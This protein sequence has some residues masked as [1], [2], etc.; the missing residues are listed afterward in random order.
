MTRWLTLVFALTAAAAHAAQ[1]DGR[2]APGADGADAASPGAQVAAGWWDRL[3]PEQRERLR[4][5]WQQYREFGPESREAL[6]RRF[7]SLE[8]ERELLYRRMSEEERRRFE[9]MDDA[10]RRRFLDERLR[11]RFHDRADRWR[12]REPGLTEGLGDLTPEESSRRV[13]RFVREAHLDRARRELD[14]A[15]AEGWVGP[16][17]AEWLAQSSPDELFTAVGQ[18]QRWRFLDRAQRDGFWTKHGIGAEDRSRML[19]LPI[20][21]FFE[22]VRRLE[23][24]EPLLGPPCDWRRDGG[25]HGFDREELH[26]REGGRRGP[27]ER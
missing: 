1:Q 24:G 27:P 20:P 3:A 5:R 12:R 8:Q 21:H 11:M 18:I 6:Q 17:A 16:A 4:D 19:E 14:E 26:R 22:E 25:R 7:E 10:E 9:S 15:V 23:R 13:E 2:V